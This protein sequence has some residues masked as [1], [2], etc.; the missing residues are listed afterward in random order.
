MV[1]G[2]AGAAT[3]IGSNLQGTPTAKK[4]TAAST[5]TLSV[6]A[7]PGATLT[8]PID[9]VIVRWR[10]KFG[11]L[12]NPNIEARLHILHGNT[13]TEEGDLIH[14]PEVAGTIETQSRVPIKKGDRIGIDGG[15]VVLAATPGAVTQMWGDGLTPNA[16][17]PNETRPPDTTL[18]GQEL[19][20]N[21]DIEADAD[22]DEYGDETQ[23]IC[24]PGQS[25]SYCPHG[26][27]C[28]SGRPVLFRLRVEAAPSIRHRRG[29]GAK[30]ASS[31][32]SSK[33]RS[34]ACGAIITSRIVRGIRHFVT[35]CYKVL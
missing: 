23:D 17:Q 16:L 31:G 4:C 28:A 8:S 30:K 35:R 11:A 9:G 19:L 25:S 21:A 26:E 6:S 32:R 14:L 12:S 10:L 1:P 33:A 34:A 20:L 29:G 18:D 24:P 22:H 5:C 2:S 7:L 15:G 3:T 27:A 13:D